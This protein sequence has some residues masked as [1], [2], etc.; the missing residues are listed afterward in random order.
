MLPNPAAIT[1]PDAVEI[2]MTLRLA[3]ALTAV[4]GFAAFAGDAAAQYDS[5]RY[6]YVPGPYRGAPLPADDDD[7][8][9]PPRPRYGVPGGY[10]REAAPYPYETR[11]PYDRRYDQRPYDRRYEQAAPGLPRPSDVDRR[12]LYDP[13]QGAVPGDYVGRPGGRA[14]APGDLAVRPPQDPPPVIRAPGERGFAGPPQDPPPGMRPPTDLG[15]TRPP[16]DIAPSG[17][18]TGQPRYAAL[19]PG[20][21]PEEGPAKELPAHLKRQLVDYQTREVAGTIVIDTANTYLYLV[22]GN[23]KAMRYGIGVGREGFTWSGRERIS[24]MAEWPD[25][26]PPAEMIERQPYLPRFMAGGESNPLGARALY[27]GKTLFRIHGTNQPSTIGSFV[28]SGCVRLT[29]ADIEDLYGRVT[30][31]A[32]VVVLPGKPPATTGAAAQR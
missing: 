29:N 2:P 32:A 18:P 17:Q 3:G 13:Y 15:A 19:P 6:P 5:Y 11:P 14:P 22:L 8:L 27:L 9:E 31:G 20:D 21:E 16:M 26:H 25:W 12:P 10:R 1:A 23:G 4:I 30:V 28:S 24:R 7:D